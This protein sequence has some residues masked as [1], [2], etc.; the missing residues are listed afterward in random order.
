MANITQHEWEMILIA[1]FKANWSI[2]RTLYAADGDWLPWK[3]GERR[4][5]TSRERIAELFS[6]VAG[7]QPSVTSTI[8]GAT[9]QVRINQPVRAFLDRKAPLAA[10]AL[11]DGDEK[12]AARM[13]RIPIKTTKTYRTRMGITTVD[14]IGRELRTLVKTTRFIRARELTKEHDWSTVK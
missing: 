4:P 2:L 6:N 9:L 7:L 8:R 13:M 1:A 14:K 10:S 11:W 12:K 3:K 5:Q